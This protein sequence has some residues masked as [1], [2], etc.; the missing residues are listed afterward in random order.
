[1]GFA[2]A[3]RRLPARSAPASILP[4]YTRPLLQGYRRVLF[5]L[6]VAVVAIIYGTLVA[7]YG[8]MLLE[9]FAPLAVFAVFLIWLLPD[10][11]TPPKRALIVLFWSFLTA[12]LLWPDYLALDLPGLPWITAL[13]LFGFPLALTFLTCLAVSPS[14]RTQLKQILA[15]APMVWKGLT[16]F[17]IICA[18]SVVYSTSPSGSVDKLVVAALYW[19]L[20]FFVSS[21]VFSRPGSVTVFV[22]AI[23]GTII[24]IVALGLWEQRMSQVPWAGNIP[25]FLAVGD[26]SVQR[27]LAGTARAATGVYRVQGK[28]STSLGLAEFLGLTTPFVLHLMLTARNWIV[29]VAALI[30]LPLMFACIIST[31]SR[32]GVVGFMLSFLF[33]LFFW[34]YMRRRTHRQGMIGTAIV[35]AYPLILVGFL[36]STMF[37]PRVSSMVWGSGAQQAS[38][39]ARRDQY[40]AGIPMVVARPW[41][42]GIGRGASQLGFVNRVG[43]GTIDTYV[44][45]VALDVG[46]IG[47]ISYFGLFIAAVYA[48]AIAVQNARDRETRLLI[49]LAIALLNFL[50]IKTILSQLDNHPLIFAMLGATVALVYRAQAKEP[51]KDALPSRG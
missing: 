26:E 29:R 40:N 35:I 1:M 51:E 42:Y 15:S 19:G 46:I 13:R 39:N 12:Q 6:F 17:L 10:T 2:G 34:G 49:P 38:T 32:L 8:Y 18:L 45:M 5:V 24:V 21:Y 47:L 36:A 3:L 22:W 11:E 33:Y 14:M 50:V 16:A 4:R 48:A 23:W 7:R 25:S 43:V 27:I 31:D 28:F 9:L 44:L 20:I 37:V 41:G 30:T